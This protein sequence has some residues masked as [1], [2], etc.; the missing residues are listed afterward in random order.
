M[1]RNACKLRCAQISTEDFALLCLS[2]ISTAT[3]SG[4]LRYSRRRSSKSSQACM[5]RFVLL[6]RLFGSGMCRKLR[7]GVCKTMNDVI[8][9]RSGGTLCS[10]VLY[11][12]WTSKMSDESQVNTCS[13]RDT[14]AKWSECVHGDATNKHGTDSAIFW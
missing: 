13:W 6:S 11:R 4:N 1:D 5:I 2:Y 10:R 9:A 7:K 3:R 8:M 12:R 14:T